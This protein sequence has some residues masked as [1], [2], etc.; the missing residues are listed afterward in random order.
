MTVSH[1][2]LTLAGTAG[3]LR[4]GMLLMEL[5]VALLVSSIIIAG[6]HASLAISVRSIPDSDGS[7]A[8]ALRGT[9]IADQLATE[10]ETAVHIT[11]RSATTIGFTV[12]DRDGDGWDERIRYA[13]TGV[14][15]GPLT[16][17]YNES[18]P[19]TIA[20]DVDQFNLTPSFE[21][22][23]E[24]YP[25]VGVEDAS[26]SLLIDYSATTDPAD[27]EI[28]SDD[29]VGQHFALTLP[30]GAY[31]WRP[32]RVQVVARK[33]SFSFF[34]RTIRAQMLDATI[35]L[36]PNG[37]SYEQ[38][39]M[40]VLLSDYAWYQAEFDKLDP[41]A[42]GSALCLVLDRN[43]SNSGVDLRSTRAASGL[44]KSGN[45]GTTWSYDN[46]KS[47]VSRLY[48]KLIRSG[49]TL[50]INSNYLTSM[51]VTMRMKPNTPSLNWTVACLNH[52]ELLSNQWE[53][54]FSE[55]PTTID[56]NGD[57][58]G[59]WIV[60][61]S[62][63]FDT[64]SLVDGVWRTNGTQLNTTPDCDFDTPTVVDVK[65]QNTTV[66][67]NGATIKINAFR[68]EA[69]C[70]PVLAALA[71]QPDGSQTLTLATKSSDADTRTLIKVPGLPNQPVFL[72]LILDPETSSVSLSINE[73]QYGTYA[74]SV[75]ESTDT[76]RSV[77]LGADVSDVEYS[78]AR[79]RVM[80]PQP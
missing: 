22:V 62:D 55:D 35:N 42:S 76:T 21:S 32:T 5:V 16:R 3:C 40:Y 45:G 52:P 80:E 31:A 2:S 34:Y 8:S 79:V 14:P 77:C 57:A 36:T 54:H 9:R 33:A 7:T 43:Q 39:T 60:D 6:L 61:D 73:V 24:T 49:G 26:E 11:E 27:N 53:T 51:G 38:N 56:V 70:V 47:L 66:G 25:S 28:K 13:W 12:P 15:G 30:A 48:G 75:F 46:G 69:T 44:L 64:D 37:S 29:W 23:A 74:L 1:P 17:Q 50:S 72:H 10:L 41:H 78:Y 20:E 68:S 58:T 71:K 63:A 59:D 4:R 65:F 18:T 19:L 67:G